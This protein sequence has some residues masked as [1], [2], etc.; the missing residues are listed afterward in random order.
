MADASGVTRIGAAF[1]RSSAEGRAALIPYVMAGDPDAATSVEVALAIAAAGADIIELGM[2][3]SDPLADGPTIQAAAARSLAAGTTIAACLQMVE[4][5]AASTDVPIVVMGYAN[6][7]LQFGVARFCRELAAAGGAGVIVA[8]MPPEEAG[9]LLAAAGGE[10]LAVIFLVAPTSGDD[11]IRE[12]AAAGT[13]FLYCVS[14]T[15][16]T[17]ARSELSADLPAFLERVRAAS[18]LPVAVGFGVAT[19]EH[20]AQLA[21]LVDG[22]VV[23]SAL[24]TRIVDALPGDA[25]HMAAAFVADLVAAARTGDAAR[26]T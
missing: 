18:E 21:P 8:D 1:T 6:P 13:G 20:V 15:G 5:V 3:F 17:G 26:S 25:A 4:Q 12:V 24:V 2:P 16:V 22:V 7:V 11:R 14:L 9:D 23:G 10:G 19:T